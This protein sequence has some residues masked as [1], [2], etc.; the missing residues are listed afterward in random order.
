LEG[1]CNLYPRSRAGC[2]SKSGWHVGLAG[3]YTL[4]RLIWS[5]MLVR[6]VSATSLECNLPS[7]LGH[8][9]PLS[10]RDGMSVTDFGKVSVGKY[11]SLMRGRFALSEK[12]FM[13]LGKGSHCYT[14]VLQV[15][16]S[17]TQLMSV[18]HSVKVHPT[19]HDS[20]ARKCYL[21]RHVGKASK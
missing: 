4:G 18:T 8:L 3:I 17:A 2:V 12:C 10:S 6:Q 11:M 13:H 21:V 1:L 20:N 19:K 5:G 7:P 16:N 14:F 15:L 9:K